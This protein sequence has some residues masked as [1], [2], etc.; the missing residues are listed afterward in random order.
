MND[1]DQLVNDAKKEI[2]NQEL[3][4]IN[5]FRNKYTKSVPVSTALIVL[6]IILWA[7]HFIDNTVTDETIR[8]DVKAL[9]LEAKSSIAEYYKIHHNLPPQI[10][11]PYLRSVILYDI[12]GGTGSN[13]Q[14]TLIGRIDGV[15]FTLN[16]G[17]VGL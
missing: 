10:P 7:K 1:L 16:Q 11:L 17:T 3:T 4:R 15:S 5:R 13:H 2:E 8:S 6:A 9:V 14:Y 12:T